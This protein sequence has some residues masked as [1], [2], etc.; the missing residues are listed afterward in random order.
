MIILYT[1]GYDN[2]L[3]YS[4][5]SG[6]KVCD[7]EYEGKCVSELKYQLYKIEE[8]YSVTF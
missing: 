3:Y 1:Y 7:Y 4:D 8:K 6:H 5:L 2:P